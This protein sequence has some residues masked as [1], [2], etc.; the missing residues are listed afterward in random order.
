M[1]NW[2]FRRFHKDEKVEN[3]AAVLDQ[4]AI[5]KAAFFAKGGKVEQVPMSEY[6]REKLSPYLRKYFTQTFEGAM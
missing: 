6:K 3:R 4:L 5:D 1:S 2:A